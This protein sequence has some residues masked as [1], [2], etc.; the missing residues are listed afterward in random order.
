[1]VHVFTQLNL[2]QGLKKFGKAVVRATK[3]EMQKI[4]YKVVL[5]PIRGEQLTR[6]QKNGALKVLFFLKQK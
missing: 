5:H 4:Q 2:K 3:S 1:M 6:K